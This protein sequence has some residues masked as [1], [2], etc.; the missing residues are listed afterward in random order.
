[1][2][3]SRAQEYERSR[4]NLGHAGKLKD[5]FK[6]RRPLGSGISKIIQGISRVYIG[7]M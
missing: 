2:L 6:D 3:G 7:L 1:M 4:G 5:C